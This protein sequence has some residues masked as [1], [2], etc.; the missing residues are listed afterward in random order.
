MNE[1]LK[2]SRLPEFVAHYSEDDMRYESVKDHLEQVAELAAM[3]ARSFGAESW[4]YTVGLAHD[5]GKYSDAFQR[6]ILRNGPKV[7]HATAGA[8]LVVATYP[9]LL[10]RCLAFPIAG[11]HGGMPNWASTP[12]QCSRTPLRERLSKNIEPYSEGCGKEISLPEA[13]K[14]IAKDDLPPC[15]TRADIQS[16]EERSFGLYLT[17]QLLYSSLVDA[18]YLCTEHFM[19]PELTEIRADSSSVSMSELATILDIHMKKLIE[20]AKPGPVN[21]VRSKVLNQCL[22][23]ADADAGLFSLEVPTGGGKTLA[24]MSFALHHAARNGQKRVIVAIPF[25]SIVEQTAAIL[26][27]IFGSENVLEHHSDYEYNDDGDGSTERERLLVENWDAP[28]IVTTNVQLF[29]S[30]FSNKPSKCRKIHN[31]A[32]AVIVLDEAQTLPDALLRPTLAMI[33]VLAD[34]AGSSTVLCTATQP[35]LEECWPFPS[36]PK[37]IVEDG[38]G[39][40]FTPLNGRIVYDCAHIGGD[41]LS[42]AGLVDSLAEVPQVL[43][44]V[45]SQD[46]ARRIYEEVKETLRCAG[47]QDGLFHL[48]ARMIPAHR[49]V[50]IEEI[51]RRLDAG[52]ECRVVST[53]LIEA[54]VDVD[55]PIVFREA[56][57]ID[58][59]IQ[60]AGRCNREGKLEGPGRVV[61]FECP[62]LAKKRMNWLGQMRALGL[63]VIA[64]GER[65]GFDPFGAEGVKRFFAQRYGHAQGFG[66][67]GLDKGGIYYDLVERDGVGMAVS[68]KFSFESYANAYRIIDDSG[69]SVFVPWGDAGQTILSRVEAGEISP[70]LRHALQRYS[71]SVPGWLAST[72]YSTVFRVVGPFTVLETRMG[73]ESL[74]SGEV[75]LLGVGE[76]ELEMLVI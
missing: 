37:A 63:Y 30:L 5:V 65:E 64:E 61:V 25:M 20:S 72:E 57:G 56:A 52:L 10:G 60:A 71:V 15:F 59:I 55:F 4:A 66:E 42:L 53:Q 18:D 62:D 16:T 35:N 44:I 29:E 47:P 70:N 2:D 13:D 26:K 14:L 19:A 49:S 46:G 3:F 22:R 9:E 51:R 45:S 23:A 69:I 50:F 34:Y 40:L 31:A 11:H 1:H 75:G 12:G 21:D 28:I 41:Q 27:A 36:R 73:S 24:A 74:Y 43:C 54:G 68:G 38:D 67:D 7:D 8:Q 33:Q 17:E 58:S 76:G 39:T 6:R 32:S 48:S